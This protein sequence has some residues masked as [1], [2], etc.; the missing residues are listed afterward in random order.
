MAFESLVWNRK[1]CLL[2]VI[3]KKLAFI[4]II[5]PNQSHDSENWSKQLAWWKSFNKIKKYSKF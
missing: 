4:K 1:L 5:R 3:N 2:E